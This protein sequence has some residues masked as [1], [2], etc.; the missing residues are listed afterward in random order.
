MRAISATPTFVDML[1]ERLVDVART[2]EIPPITPVQAESEIRALCATM[3]GLEIQWLLD[4][5]V[6][7][8]G[9][10]DQYLDHTLDRW[11]QGRY[12]R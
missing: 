11:R 8:V 4:P 6:D 2:G 12:A 3:D 5:T 10:F 1:A 9:L 7:L